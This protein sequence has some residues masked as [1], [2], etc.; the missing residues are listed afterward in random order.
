M[1]DHNITARSSSMEKEK[2]VHMRNI[3][4]LNIAVQDG[5]IVAVESFVESGL[6]PKDV[7]VDTLKM[8]ITMSCRDI[9]SPIQEHIF[10]TF[11]PKGFC[12]R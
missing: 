7:K 3:E 2:D 6:G 12:V 11:S 1:D 10:K 8:V 4:A 9:E 5:D